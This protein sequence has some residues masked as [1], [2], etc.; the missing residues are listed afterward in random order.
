MS[1]NKCIPC[2]SPTMVKILTIGQSTGRPLSF[3]SRSP[4]FAIRHTNLRKAANYARQ[5]SM[6]LNNCPAVG[7]GKCLVPMQMCQRLEAGS[8]RL[9]A[10]QHYRR[11]HHHRHLHHTAIGIME[12][13][14]GRPGA[15][16][17]ACPK[18][19]PRPEMAR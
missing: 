14:R 3:C 11:H 1:F 16:R 2:V 19:S 8:W 6:S 10:G 9:E 7:L 15:T 5:Q 17:S 4:S 12:V 13:R 18:I